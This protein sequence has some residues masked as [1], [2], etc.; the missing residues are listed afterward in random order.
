[1]AAPAVADQSA[2]D[3]IEEI[4]KDVNTAR[5]LE[6]PFF[7]YI[8]KNELTPEQLRTFFQ[9]YYVIV[10]TS[11]KMLAAGIL[12]APCDQPDLIIHLTKF[13][14]T[15]S[16]GTPNH[17]VY[18]QRWA[19]SFGVTVPTLEATQF[20][21]RSREFE[22][23]LMSYYATEDP[24]PMLAA[25]CGVEDCAAVLIEGLDRGFKRYPMNSRAYGYLAAHRLLEND[26]DGHS[27][28][29]IDSLARSDELRTRLD[30]VEKIYRR[31]D[32]AFVG[33]FDGIYEQWGVGKPTRKGLPKKG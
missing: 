18:Y 25:Q 19:D 12:H 20:N 3:V 22:D 32:E 30:D 5:M 8:E 7:R 14:E 2:L 21:K 29:A 15:E 26:E 24:L 27:R 28:W 23:T 4:R 1:M 9:Q 13:L 33:V 17:L 11:Y 6:T 10:K 31:V 16:G